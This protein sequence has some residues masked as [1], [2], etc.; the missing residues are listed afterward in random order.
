MCA[1]HDD[2]ESGDMRSVVYR[3]VKWSLILPCICLLY[4]L[5][6]ELLAKGR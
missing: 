6:I 3:A 1:E 4:I 2:D 5:V